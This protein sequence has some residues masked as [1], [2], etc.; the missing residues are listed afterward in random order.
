VTSVADDLRDELRERVARLT[1]SERV[2]LALELG[3][4]DVAMYAQARC[5]DRETAA[6]VLAA[7][8]RVGRIRSACVEPAS[9]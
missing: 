4:R 8:R 3:A 1:G 7:S 9:D 6:K 2:A 5:V